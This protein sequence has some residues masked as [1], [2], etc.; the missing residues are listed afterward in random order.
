MYVHPLRDSIYGAECTLLV[1]PIE[2]LAPWLERHDYPTDEDTTRWAEGKTQQFTRDT[3]S[4][5]ILWLP[6]TARPDTVSHECVH[7]AAQVLRDCDVRLTRASEEAYAYYQS[8]MFDQ[9]SQAL[10]D[11]RRR[12]T[13]TAKK[14]T[15]HKRG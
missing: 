1:G 12:A 5:W 3:Y 9:V 11:L 8:S 7:L 6:A 2:Q 10:R 14:K 13:T 4:E 15:T